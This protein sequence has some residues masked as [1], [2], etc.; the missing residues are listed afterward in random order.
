MRG[1]LWV[2]TGLI[3]GFV[4]GSWTPLGQ[5]V[6]RDTLERTL[7]SLAQGQ[8]SNPA[9]ETQAA[10]QV[11]TLSRFRSLI[12]AAQKE[13]AG[14]ILQNRGI[15]LAAGF[16]D[17]EDAWAMHYS[18]LAR[19][20]GIAF[21]SWSDAASGAQGQT[22]NSVTAAMPE[23]DINAWYSQTNAAELA[24][25]RA[26]IAGIRAENTDIENNL[27]NLDPQHPDHFMALCIHASNQGLIAFYTFLTT[28]GEKGVTRDDTANL[29]SALAAQLASASEHGR[30]GRGTAA[31]FAGVLKALPTASTEEQRVRV[32][33]LEYYESFVLSFDLEDTLAAHLAA[34]PALI[35][36]AIV[37]REPPYEVSQWVAD[38]QELGRSRMELQAYR[39]QIAADLA[40]PTH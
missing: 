33:A 22:Q 11:A 19:S 24:R 25:L 7:F 10:T 35:D 8:G 6:S 31:E 26:T 15:I 30:S 3:A 17:P 29:T 5:V 40:G 16:L 13:P 36:A 9:G 37:S 39:A 1:K 38:F 12:T 4:L 28:M 21:A 32:R 2:T 27:A 18:E 14:N 20:D 23:T 34:Y